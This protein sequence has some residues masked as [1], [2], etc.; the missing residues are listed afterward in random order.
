[1]SPLQVRFRPFDH[2][3]VVNDAVRLVSLVPL[4]KKDE[5]KSTNYWVFY[6]LIWLNL[7]TCVHWSKYRLENRTEHYWVMVW[8]LLTLMQQRHQFVPERASGGSR[9]ASDSAVFRVQNEVL[10]VPPR[11]KWPVSVIRDRFSVWLSHIY[12]AYFFCALQVRNL[13]FDSDSV[14]FYDNLTVLINAT[15]SFWD[16]KM[17]IVLQVPSWVIALHFRLYEQEQ[18]NWNH[19]N[20]L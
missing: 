10:R 18:Q 8:L 9:P 11:V 17:T 5:W 3:F 6:L 2:H 16:S 13:L 7:M 12:L 14:R 1:M 15:I 20:H 19:V 4:V